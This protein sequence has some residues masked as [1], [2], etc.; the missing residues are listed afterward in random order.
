M[1]IFICWTC[2]EL[3]HFSSRCPRRVQKSRKSSLS[4]EDNQLELV[5]EEV[6]KE[7][8]AL[9]TIIDDYNPETNRQNVKKILRD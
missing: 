1:K 7:E 9:V 8:L 3:G 4:D 5:K 6:V 2:K